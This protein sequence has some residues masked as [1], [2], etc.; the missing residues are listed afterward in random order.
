MVWLPWWLSGNKST[1]YCRRWRFDARVK[2]IPGERNVKPLQYSCLG[3]PGTEEPGGLQSMEFQK[4]QT[5][6][7]YQTTTTNKWY[8]MGFRAS[9]KGVEGTVLQGVTFKILGVISIH[10]SSLCLHLLFFRMTLFLLVVP[11]QPKETA[12]CF[13]S[14]SLWANQHNRKLPF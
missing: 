5:W 14:F 10:S 3:I 7:N 6:L 1:C 12:G 13:L 11:G 2:K 9:Y 4:C 8:R